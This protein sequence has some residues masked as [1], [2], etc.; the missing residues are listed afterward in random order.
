MVNKNRNQVS[1]K[2]VES[3]ADCRIRVRYAET[4]QMGVAYYGNYF[5]WFEVGRTEF[6]R[7]H[8]FSYKEMEDKAE[9]FLPVSEA[10]CRYLRPLRYDSEFIVRTY[11]NEL[12]R[13]AVTFVY[14]IL[15]LNGEEVYAEGKTIHIVTDRT[16]KPKTFPEH[17]RDLL[18]E[19]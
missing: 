18:L 10:Y 7:Q 1:E 14:Q 12:R 16:G 2:G 8:G 9:R 17:Y 5:A 4:D 6:C 3:Y 15:D 11:V 13:R 19:K